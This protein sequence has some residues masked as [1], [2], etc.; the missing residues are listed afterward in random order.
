MAKLWKI[1]LDHDFTQPNIQKRDLLDSGYTL[2]GGG[3]SRRLLWLLKYGHG[4]NCIWHSDTETDF[5]GDDNNIWNSMFLFD[6]NFLS[7]GF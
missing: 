4:R 2:G 3:L 7:C 6:M 5:E 1:C